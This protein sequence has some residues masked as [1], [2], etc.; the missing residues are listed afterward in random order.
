MAFGFLLRTSGCASPLRK[1]KMEIEDGVTYD[2]AIDELDRRSKKL[3]ETLIL[4]A[5][6]IVGLEKEFNA[7]LAF[8]EAAE[9]KFKVILIFMYSVALVILLTTAYLS[10][11]K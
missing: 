10:L 5:K 11:V 7:L 9:K 4:H 3:A 8:K 1:F 2:S 6:A